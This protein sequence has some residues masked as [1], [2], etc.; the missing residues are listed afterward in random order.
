MSMKTLIGSDCTKIQVM[1]NRPLIITPEIKE[2]L[3][4]LKEYAE[5]NT[6]SMD[7]LL[8]MYNKQ[9]P[10][11][12]D[13]KEHVRHIP[14]GFRVVYSTEN[15]T[16]G[17]IKHLSISIDEDNALPGIPAVELIMKELGFEDGLENCLIN[18]EEISEKRKA[19]SVI[20]IQ[21]K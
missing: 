13:I 3:L 2:E 7:D 20:Q 16:K 9:K 10:V 17:F 11:A 18:L 4:S 1:K 6:Y 12:G 21:A 5:K 14:V 19:I 8:D 15:Q